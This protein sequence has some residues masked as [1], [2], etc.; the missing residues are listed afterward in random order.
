M[1]K[2]QRLLDVEILEANKLESGQTSTP[3]STS[4]LEIFYADSRLVNMCLPRS[5]WSLCMFY[6]YCEWPRLPASV[7]IFGLFSMPCF[8]LR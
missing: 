8:E 3:D 6:L 7:Y 4:I 5:C 2:D 1:S